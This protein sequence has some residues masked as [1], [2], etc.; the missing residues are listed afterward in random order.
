[1]F[2][3]NKKYLYFF[4]GI[5]ILIVAVQYIL[6]K[7][8]NWNRTYLG[9]DK[10]AF[11][12]YA[13][14]ELMSGVYSRTLTVNKATF[15]NLQNSM[16]NKSSVLLINDRFDLNKNDM[17]ALYKM[18]DEGSTVF[19]AANEFLGAIADS[20]HVRC[21]Y[22]AFSLFGNMDSLLV[23]PGSDIT[24]LASNYKKKKFAYPQ[25]AWI[26]AFTHFDTTKFEVLATTLKNKACL[27][28]GSFGKGKLYL[29]TAPDIF[30]NYFIV[31]NENRELAYAMLSLIKNDVVVWDEYYKTYN[32][33]NYSFLKFILESDALYSA[34]LLFLFT[35]ILYMITEG[36]RRQRA[37]PILEPVKNTTLEFVNVISHVYF[38]A[39]NHKNISSEMIRYFFDEIRK[40][41]NVNTLIIDEGLITEVTILSGIE[42]KKVKQ[43]FAYCE[44]LRTSNDVTELDLIELN[45]QINNFN[46]NSLR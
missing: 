20:L 30:S 29:M 14:K 44:K 33:T 9:K 5:F 11:G 37:I 17:K 18:L 38:N 3:D 35:I 24:L 12:T 46:T 10:A 42:N 43:L 21:T 25:A 22:N 8:T 26:S 31:K 15:Y 19:M 36:R 40:K 16:G 13:I 45:R 2:R 23:K 4:V 28:R 27:I 6:P 34:Y 39:K 41:F 7:P 32:V 1:M